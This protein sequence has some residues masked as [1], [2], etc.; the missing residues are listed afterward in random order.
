M[1]RN[2]MVK[3]T[4]VQDYLVIPCPGCDPSGE[5]NV[6]LNYAGPETKVWGPPR[7]VSVWIKRFL[8]GE[9]H[10]F[11][12]PRCEVVR[13][14]EEIKWEYWALVIEKLKELDDS[15]EEKK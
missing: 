11:Q 12:C 13:T 3:W 10:F 15:A 8:F 14:F 5:C 9:E 4:D 7:S 1:K 2:S 6:F